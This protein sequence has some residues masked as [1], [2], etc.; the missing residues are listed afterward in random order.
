M[1]RLDREQVDARRRK[2]R[3]AMRALRDSIDLEEWDE[4]S[5]VTVQAAPGAIVNVGGT[6]KFAAVDVP[7]RPDNPAPAPPSSA[8]T[9]AKGIAHVLREV[10]TWPRVVGLALLVLAIVVALVLRVALPR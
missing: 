5:A 8:P 2:S 10:N 3:E 1:G 4:N 9:V 6:G 7:T